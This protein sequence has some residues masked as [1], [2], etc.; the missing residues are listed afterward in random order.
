MNSFLMTSEL[1]C[2]AD[3]AVRRVEQLCQRHTQKGLARRQWADAD[4][5][6]EEVLLHRNGVHLHSPS[7]CPTNH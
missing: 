3:R 4:N 6:Q 1:Q 7:P 2:A 5:H